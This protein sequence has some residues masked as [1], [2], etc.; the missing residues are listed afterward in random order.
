MEGPTHQAVMSDQKRRLQPSRFL[1]QTKASFEFT[2]YFGTS[3]G[4]FFLLRWVGKYFQHPTESSESEEG[5]RFLLYLATQTLQLLGRRCHEPHPWEGKARVRMEGS[6]P[7][8]T[9]P[10]ASGLPPCSTH[11]ILK[12]T[13]WGQGIL[14]GEYYFVYTFFPNPPLYSS[15]DL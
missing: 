12:C 4:R 6:V 13:F 8:A 1:L 11:V 2:E 7:M 10:S 9:G 15:K 5:G 14:K 3:P